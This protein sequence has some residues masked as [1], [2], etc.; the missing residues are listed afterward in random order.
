MFERFTDRS[1]RVLVLAQEESRL[2]GHDFIGTEHLLLGLIGEGHGVAATT[3]DSLGISLEA[4]RERV[5]EAVGKGGTPGAG[6]PPFTPRAK[7]V[8]EL[9]LREALQLGQGH[10][11]TEHLLFGLVREGEGGG[12][13]VLAGLGADSDRVRERLIEHLSGQ[14]PQRPSSGTVGPDASFSPADLSGAAAALRRLLDAPP[15]RDAREGS[16]MTGRL[17]GAIAALEELAQGR[18]P[19]P[20]DFS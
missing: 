12:I 10:I 14:I 1:R 17:E 11:G 4:A 6:S 9:S 13:Q 8:L 20:D 2:L 16:M 5:V 7:K 15:S 3:L 18:L 19:S